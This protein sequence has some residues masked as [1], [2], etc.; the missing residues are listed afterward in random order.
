[1][2][3]LLLS[4]IGPMAPWAD[5]LRAALPD[6]DIRTWPDAGDAGEIT[7]LVVARVPPGVLGGFPNARLIVGLRAGVDDLLS[8]PDLPAGVPV[9]RAGD[10]DGDA[11]I[12]EYVLMH[13]LRHHRNM[14]DFIAAQARCEWINPA[15]A[16]ASERT[17]GFLGLGL[18]GL[19]CARMVRD[20]GFRV[21]AWTRTPKSEPGIESFHGAGQL[22]DFLARSE[23]VVNLLA[24]TDETK[25]ILCAANFARL[26]RGASVINIGRGQHVVEEDL[27]AALDSGHLAAATLDV[28]RTEPLPKES[29]LW[30]HPRITVMPHT[31]RRPRAADIVPQVAEHVRRM[32]AGRA[33]TQTV[34]RKAGY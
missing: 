12:S 10:P 23:I 11:Q 4:T 5:M 34:D 21:A 27:M 22:G 32:E 28:Y 1:M 29:P 33:L 18:I 14:P 31:S 30:R 24:V 15:V 19:P 3:V 9:V 8:D 7:C 13:V 25:D 2:A 16:K 6:M 20:I 26:P 17:V